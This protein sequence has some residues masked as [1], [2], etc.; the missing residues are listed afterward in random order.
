M[1]DTNTSGVRPTASG[2]TGGAAVRAMRGEG[3]GRYQPVQ[4]TWFEC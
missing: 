2:V 1:A 3:K 4:Q